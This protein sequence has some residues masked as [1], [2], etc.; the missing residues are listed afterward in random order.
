MSVAP[1]DAVPI[2]PAAAESHRSRLQNLR[3]ADR[4]LWNT[5]ISTAYL[6]GTMTTSELKRPGSGSAPSAD[7][8]VRRWHKNRNFIC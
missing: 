6:A 2:R 7:C 4:S 1:N 3:V 8:R 5:S